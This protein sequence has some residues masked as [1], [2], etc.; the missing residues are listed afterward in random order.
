MMRTV[1]PLVALLACCGLVPWAVQAGETLPPPRQV[2]VFDTRNDGGGSLTVTWA[3]A[4]REDKNLK[5]QVLLQDPSGGEPKVIAEF[6][7][8]SHYVQDTKAPWWTMPAPKDAHQFTVKSGKGIELKDGMS[9]A[10]T[11]VALSGDQRAPA[12]PVRATPEADWFNWNQINNLAIVVIFGFVVLGSIQ[13]AKRREIFLRRIAGLDAVDEA[14][15][16]A[17][18]LGKPILYLTG[19][20][21]GGR[22]RDRAHGSPPRSHRDGRLPGNHQA[23]LPR[24]GK[25]GR[26]QGGL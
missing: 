14:I 10:V 11:V 1:G 19:R 12:A 3:K 5:Y 26:L 6:T 20:Q 7:S 9:Y 16:R 23:I 24:S 4:D 17:T 21:A 2:Q 15:G 18:E 25:A 22:L 8:D 13:A